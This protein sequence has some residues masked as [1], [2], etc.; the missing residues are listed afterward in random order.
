MGDNGQ[1]GVVMVVKML[2]VAVS[3]ACLVVGGEE[4]WRFL[5]PRDVDP[6]AAN[7]SNPVPRRW[8]GQKASLAFASVVKGDGSVK[9]DWS[10]ADAAKRAPKLRGDPKS[11]W[12][13]LTPP[14]DPVT[15]P[16]LYAVGRD[17]R[18]FR[19]NLP[20]ASELLPFIVVV[21]GNPEDGYGGYVLGADGDGAWSFA[22]AKSSVTLRGPSPVAHRFDGNW[23][24][25][26][27]AAA[28]AW[29]GRFAPPDGMS[30]DL[31]ISVVAEWVQ[32]AGK[33]NAPSAGWTEFLAGRRA[34][35]AR[36]LSDPR[37]AATLEKGLL[38]CTRRNPSW[39][40]CVAQYFG[41]RQRPGGT[42]R[43]LERP[44]RSLETRDFLAGRMPS[45]TCLEPRLSF[46]ARTLLFAFVETEGP[47]DPYS[48]RVNEEG[49]D[50]HY[51]HLWRVNV[52]GTGLKQLTKGVYED[53]M[54]CW[55]PDGGVA[56]MSSRRRS[57]SRCFWYGYSNRWQAYTLFRM[58]PDGSEIRQLSWNDVAEW[59]PALSAEGEI[60]FARWD[61]IDRDAVRH[62]NLWSVRPDGTNPKAVWGNETT[63]PHCT[64]QPCA[65][66]GSGKIACIASAHHAVTGGPLILIDPSV[67]ENSEAAITHVT[68]GHYP[69][70]IPRKKHDYDDVSP[71]A[72][73]DWYNSP[74]AYGEDLF[75]ISWS[76]DP[77]GYEPSRPIPDAAL[78]L[79]VL[80][81][82]GTRELLWRDGQYGACAAQPLVPRAAPP[83]VRS[84][85]DPKLAA[86]K[87]G[88]VFISD[89][90]RGLQN[91]PTGMV[92]SVR[93]VEIYP[94]T[95]PDQ[96]LP[97]LGTGGHENGRGVVGTADVESDG[98]VRFTVPAE[99]QILFQVL[100]ADGF[101]WRTM[102][103]STSLMPGERVS[104]VGCHEPKR[105]ASAA[106]KRVSLAMQRPA[107]EL[108]VPPEGGRPWGFTENVQPIFD[109]KCVSCHSGA[110]PPKGVSLT[111]DEDPRFPRRVKV[112]GIFGA[113]DDSLDK[114]M[115]CAPFSLAYATLVFTDEPT[116]KGSEYKPF[117]RWKR[118]RGVNRAGR[119][120]DMVPC[121]QEYNQVQTTPDGPGRNALGSGLMGHLSR[122]RHAK[123][124]TPEERR[125]LAT[126]ID[127]N[128]LFYSCCE[129]PGLTRQFRGEPVARP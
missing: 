114:G 43:V 95:A 18:L 104:C 12:K 10:A 129:E 25:G 103:S 89:V 42:L 101:T 117:Q 74:W 23:I 59:F 54:P 93:V 124:L 84:Q 83:I 115:V 19:D 80:A 22:L 73:N 57:Q 109:R 68:P 1:T 118:R 3:G 7:L 86:E 75:L 29:P 119:P 69:E 40:H 66:P 106:A 33:W 14:K 113:K 37:L 38:F 60:I 28:R 9:L 110:K 58:K 108:R 52:D 46:D 99:R 125:V 36:L 67:D 97:L 121:W 44:G 4:A 21:D 51:F 126:W 78:G 85:L 82:D 26:L 6:S 15:E 63:D 53:F 24:A 55:L 61:Y 45:G 31:W 32:D 34:R 77:L 100:D 62:Q 112:N 27:Q 88:E 64:F 76:R 120:A 50:D 56:F 79:Y 41:W 107:Q 87:K 39:N 13:G 8:S 116:G 20:D 111:R 17:M 70:C 128:S 16:R 90:S 48:M 47:L 91:A 5:P 65:V 72:H 71:A 11:L 92:R 30:A 102:R 49:G 122:G 105:E 35:R 98:S 96:Y 123:L 94:R 81:S 127:L 2:V